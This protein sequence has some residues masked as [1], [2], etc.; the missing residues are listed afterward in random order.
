MLRAVVGTLS[1]SWHGADRM[2]VGVGRPTGRGRLGR[3]Q[4]LQGTQLGRN[5]GHSRVVARTSNP[6]TAAFCKAED[7]ERRRIA[8]AQRD[9]VSPKRS[10][11]VNPNSAPE[12]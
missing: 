4:I 7:A 9:A 10:L 3:P 8:T 6:A 2:S 11:G 1:P 5:C 12:S